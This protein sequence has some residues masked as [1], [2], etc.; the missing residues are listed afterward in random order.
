MKKGALK[1]I[2]LYAAVVLYLLVAVTIT[3]GA[4]I[5]LETRRLYIPCINIWEVLFWYILVSIWAA[6]LIYTILEL[7]RR[8]NKWSKW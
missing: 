1:E 7:K 5:I 2:L 4:L 8:K 3:A 6:V